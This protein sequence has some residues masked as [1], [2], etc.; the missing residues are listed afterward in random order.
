M[1]IHWE[2]STENLAFVVEDRE[3]NRRVDYDMFHRIRQSYNEEN[4]I[5]MDP[6]DCHA[7]NEAMKRAC[8]SDMDDYKDRLRSGIK[9][10]IRDFPE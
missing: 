1:D 2:E 6:Q 8:R 4:M 9:Y 3:G 10:G 5:E 7:L